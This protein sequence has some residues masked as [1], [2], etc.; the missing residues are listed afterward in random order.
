MMPALSPI[1]PVTPLQM[2]GFDPIPERNPVPCITSYQFKNVQIFSGKGNQ[3]PSIE[4]WIRDMKYLLQVK[5]PAPAEV[6]FNDIIRHTSGRA[7][8][9]ILNLEGACHG[10]PTPEC[11]FSELI[12]E[13][14]ES[15]LTR[16]P[17][18]AFFARVQQPNE[19]P[20][21]YAIA[22]EALLRKALAGKD[23]EDK[24]LCTQFMSGL[25]DKAVRDRLAPMRP[26]D[27]DYKELRRELHII[28]E[29]NRQMNGSVGLLRHDVK[30]NPKE[31]PNTT[32]NFL[33]QMRCQLAQIQLAQQQQLDTVQHLVDGHS[34]IRNRLGAL[35]DYVATPSMPPQSMSTPAMQTQ[36]MQL[37]HNMRTTPRE[38]YRCGQIGHLSR[39]CPT[40]SNSRHSNDLNM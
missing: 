36:N 20:S 28:A 13:Y 39:R 22:L 2:A 1:Q 35:E 26:R 6:M 30:P 24:T 17:M 27:M 18:A 40:R 33:E 10:I 11:V 25:R 9:V 12:D 16:S 37:N 7:R 14:G 38:C 34:E 3:G 29:E 31:K 19:S 32:E 5:G 4:D 23:R 21:E 15:S 8:D